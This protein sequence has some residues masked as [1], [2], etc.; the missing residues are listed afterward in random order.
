MNANGATRR[1]PFWTIASYL[2]R[3]NFLQTICDSEMETT[4]ITIVCRID[5]GGRG[6]IKKGSLDFGGN[7]SLVDL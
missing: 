6:E 2:I 7:A 4:L 1:N 3:Q 5:E